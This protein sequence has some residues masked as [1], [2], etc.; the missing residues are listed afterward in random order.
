MFFVHGWLPGRYDMSQGTC[1]T[2]QWETVCVTE[3]KIKFLFQHEYR[4]T[5]PVF[6]IHI[7]FV[8]WNLEFSPFCGSSEGPAHFIQKGLYC[9]ED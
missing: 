5:Q 7:K 2:H 4:I 3:L 9:S 8:L 1:H 6:Y